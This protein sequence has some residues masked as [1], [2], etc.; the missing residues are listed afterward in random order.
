MRLYKRYIFLFFYV[1][2]FTTFAQT[3]PVDGMKDNTPAVHA[4][5]NAT[6]VTEPGN[7]LTDAVLVIRNGVIESVGTNVQPP[8]RCPYL[9][10]GRKNDLSRF[11]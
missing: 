10:Y 2:P 3:T 8:C 1:I 9:G 7:V 4:F 5:T 6:I 11:Y